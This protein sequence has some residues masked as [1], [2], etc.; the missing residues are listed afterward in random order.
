VLWGTGVFDAARVGNDVFIWEEFIH[1]CVDKVKRYY[2]LHNIVIY[3]DPDNVVLRDEFS[4]FDQA[5]SRISFVS[6]LGLPTTFGDDLTALAPD[7]VDLLKRALPVQDIHPMSITG[8]LSGSDTQIVNLSV[9]LPFESYTVADILNITDKE[10]CRNIN[11]ESTLHLEEGEYLVY[12]YFRKE[13]LGI[14]DKDIALD[15]KPYESRVL[16]I[17]KKS[18]VPQI[19]STSRHITQGAQEIKDMVWNSETKTL[20]L[21]CDLV[22]DD[23]YTVLLY[24]P[25]GYKYKNSG[26]AN[27]T[28]EGNILKLTYTPEK[29]G[30]YKFDIEF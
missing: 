8:S 15:L 14:F 23:E 9:E 25:D 29:S 2:T 24:C 20:S 28:S 30:A 26:F 1:Q 5:V 27:E 4:T 17:R 21:V 11:L 19:L 7:R 16:A 3:N 13:F 18:D 22:E 6:L 10:L 12:D